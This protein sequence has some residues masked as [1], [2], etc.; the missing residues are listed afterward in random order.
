MGIIRTQKKWD[1][2][3]ESLLGKVRHK[4]SFTRTTW[5]VDSREK[6]DLETG[7]N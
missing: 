3:M 1:F 7:E 2:I 5:V 6:K 4:N